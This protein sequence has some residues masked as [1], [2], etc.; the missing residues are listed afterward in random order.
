[1]K[2]TTHQSVLAV[3]PYSSGCSKTSSSG[4]A[5]ASCPAQWQ[6]P[7]SLL[8]PYTREI[9]RLRHVHTPEV[10]FLYQK[11]QKISTDDSQKAIY[12]TT[13]TPKL[14]TPRENSPIENGRRE[15]IDRE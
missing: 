4:V 2:E 1:M 15:T 10:Y 12:L 14:L 7:T 11:S 9:A 13:Y 5:G 3:E 6:P 8:R